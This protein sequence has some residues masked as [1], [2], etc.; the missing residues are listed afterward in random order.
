MENVGNL[1]FENNGKCGKFE[2]QDCLN[3]RVNLTF[4][5]QIYILLAPLIGE[6][7]TEISNPSHKERLCRELEMHLEL[8]VTK[9]LQ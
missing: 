5:P 3:F 1:K 4:F 6:V 7:L 2:R 9:L 8:K